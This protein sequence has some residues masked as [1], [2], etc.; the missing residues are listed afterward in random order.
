MVAAM[1]IV[2]VADGG[3]VAVA[4]A[5]VTRVAVA[6]AGAGILVSVMV[7]GRA[8]GVARG[9]DLL[10]GTGDPGIGGGVAYA[11]SVGKS[12]WP[13]NISEAPAWQAHDCAA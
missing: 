5:G 2:P 1:G 9:I 13:Q 10:K 4:V 7:G 6:A 3:S 11:C 12:R 8:V